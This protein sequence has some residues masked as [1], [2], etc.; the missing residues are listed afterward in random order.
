MSALVLRRT[1]ASGVVELTLNRAERRNAL[2]T[3]LLRELHDHLSRV[4]LDASARVVV[5]AAEGPAFCAGADVA[6][7]GPQSTEAAAANRRRLLVEVLGRILALPQPTLAAVNGPAVGA[8]WGIALACDLC[9]VADRASFRLPEVRAGFKLPGVLVERLIQAVGPFH[10]AD[11]IF[12]GDLCTADDDRIAGWCRRVL[13]ADR[14]HAE[15][16]RLADGLAG[17]SADALAAAVAPLRR[18]APAGAFAELHWT[19]EK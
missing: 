3:D 2:S 9:F 6:E 7:F 16:R 17:T 8:G 19:E 13:P 11:L 18:H 14:L 5:I 1:D 10:A 15:V 4:Q 12:S